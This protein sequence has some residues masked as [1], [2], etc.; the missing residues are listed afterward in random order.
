MI[1]TSSLN[2]YNPRN[3][4]YTASSS[5]SGYPST[6]SSVHQS[7]L[8][9]T[10]SPLPRK[11]DIMSTPS[12]P[13]STAHRLHRSSR[14]N[15]KTPG[16]ED[17]SGQVRKMVQSAEQRS[18]QSPLPRK[19]SNLAGASEH[20]PP[21]K[22]KST[23]SSAAESRPVAVP[24][25]PKTAPVLQPEMQQ[26]DDLVQRAQK[27]NISKD[28]KKPREFDDWEHAGQWGQ[29]S[30]DAEDRTRRD[31]GREIGKSHDD[32]RLTFSL[33][34]GATKNCHSRRTQWN[35]LCPCWRATAD[36]PLSIGSVLPHQSTRSRPPSTSLL[37]CR[38]RVC[39]RKLQPAV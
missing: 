5:S 8:G 31:A 10:E 3:S 22:S 29:D 28:T 37:P 6:I 11:P 17:Q 35:H 15:I 23:L 1:L 2:M 39:V 19:R 30:R 32:A 9:L 13:G 38:G 25:R 33:P 27:L 20:R 21:S 24:Q 26:E 14:A 18:T 4:Q 7:I 34:T 16:R 36:S 12:T